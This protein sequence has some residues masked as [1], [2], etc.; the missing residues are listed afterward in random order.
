MRDD[1]ETVET[2]IRGDSLFE[3]LGAPIAEHRK[4]FQSR[5]SPEIYAR[6]IF[7]RALVD[8]LLRSKGNIPSPM[9]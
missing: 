7:E 6:G 5:V 2:G 9:W 3:E 4:L 8:T 1:S